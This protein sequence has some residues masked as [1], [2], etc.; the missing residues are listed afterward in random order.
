MIKFILRKR[1]KLNSISLSYSCKQRQN[2]LFSILYNPTVSFYLM[3][4]NNGLEVRHIQW[5]L[6]SQQ[7]KK[8]QPEFQHWHS[9][10]P[11]NQIKHGTHPNSTTYFMLSILHRVLLLN[12]N[13]M[14]SVNV[15]FEQKVL[16][17]P[18]LEANSQRWGHFSE[19]FALLLSLLPP[20]EMP[21][22]K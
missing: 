3:H 13:L 12:E 9:Y 18:L 4:C 8:A 17:R 6:V 11:V 1:V 19:Q 16:S 20:K 14:K 15:D 7:Q 22:D 2:F 21:R 10:W 5:P